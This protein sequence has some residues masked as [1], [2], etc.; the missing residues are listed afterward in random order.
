MAKEWYLMKSPHDQLSG[1]EGE[2]LNDFA[3]EG[4]AEILDSD[5]AVD[6]ELCN[7]DLS[8]CVSMRAII[9]NNVQDTRLKTLNR[10]VYLPIGTCKAG[11]Y[12]KYKDRFWLI[13]GLVD[14]NKMYE[15]GVM[16]L[17]NHLLT[18]INENNEIVQ[19]WCNAT[20]ASQY[21]NGETSNQFF[22]VRSDQLLILT[23]DDD[24]CLLLNTGARFIIDKRC[25]VY[26]KSFDENVTS[27]T[28]KPVIVYKLT[29]SDSVLYDYQDSGHFEFIAYQTEQ[30]NDD[31]YYVVDGNGYWLCQKPIINKTS[32]LSTEIL[33]DSDEIYN[34]LEPGVFVAK[35]YDENGDEVTNVVPTWEIK[36]DFASQLDVEYEDNSIYISANDKKLVNKSFEL[37]LSAEGYET[38]NITVVIRAFM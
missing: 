7:Y 5:L 29:R 2:A 23:P 12:V 3:E 11:M 21:N 27:D 30:G 22:F 24:E 28:T 13:I 17:C 34:G 14:D 16:I 8:E 18:W 25:R 26:E 36:S 9:Q 15:K 10:E 1:F 32:V 38:V 33:Y 6:I 37:F 31:G 4:F 20:S 19:R 35:F